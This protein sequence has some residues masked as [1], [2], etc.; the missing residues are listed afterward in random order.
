MKSLILRLKEYLAGSIWRKRI[1][2]SLIG[3]LGGYAYYYYIGC[4]TG[5]CP[6]TRNPWISTAY[7]AGMGLIL[8]IG[9]RKKQQL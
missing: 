5:T 4:S 2:F 1:L 3:A 6:I 7:G 8:T 9:E